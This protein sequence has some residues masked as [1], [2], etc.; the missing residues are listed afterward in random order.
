MADILKA[1]EKEKEYI[2]YRMKN[3][4]PFHLIDAVKDCGFESLAEYFK[5]KKKHDFEAIS[6]E[7]IETTP[8]RA[9][10]DV[11]KTIAE[12][13]TA[14][15]FADTK[16]TL[17]WNGENSTFNEDYCMEH[18]IPVYPLQTKGGTIVSTEGDLN[19]G[20]CIPKKVDIGSNT[21]LNGLADIFRK[22]TNKNIEVDGND[23]LIDGFKVLGSSVY[24]AFGMFMLITP[25]SLSEKSEL[26]KNICT[27]HSEKQP[28]HIDFMDGEMLRQE[29]LTWLQQHSF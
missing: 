8:I 15:L 1:I 24:E 26:I 18:K 16:Y 10:A 28:K 29:V 3:E 6:F 7:V 13:K 12:K 20:I 17:V 14:V 5:A 4:E 9:I 22:Y 19:I 23:I 11:L 21:I 27:K 2:S 25:V